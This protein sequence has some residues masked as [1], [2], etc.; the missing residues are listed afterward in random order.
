MRLFL[1]A[2][3]VLSAA[4]LSRVEGADLDGCWS[5]SW[6]DCNSGHSGPLRALFCRCGVDTYRVTFTGRFCGVIPFRYNVTLAVTGKEGE[7]DI[8]SG[9]SRVGILFGTFSYRAEA[10]DTDFVAEFSSCR[11]QGKFVLKR[12]CP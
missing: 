4:S 6:V 1:A 7:K 9:E 3:V 12:C 8:L 2:S 10:T 11:Y 5:G